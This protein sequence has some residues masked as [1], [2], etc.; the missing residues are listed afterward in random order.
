MILQSRIL[1][2]FPF[3]STDKLSFRASHRDQH[4][5]NFVE[6]VISQYLKVLIV[7]VIVLDF[8]VNNGIVVV[9]VIASCMYNHIV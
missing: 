4:T 6:V 9:A 2:F 3:D 5:T 1:G 7:D 8:P